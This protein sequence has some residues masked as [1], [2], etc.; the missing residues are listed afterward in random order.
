MISAAD[1]TKR[2]TDAYN[3]G[4]LAGAR[5]LLV[6]ALQI[7]PAYESAWIWLSAVVETDGERRYCLEQAQRI[8]PDRPQTVSWLAKVAGSEAAP[9]REFTQQPAVMPS[10]IAPAELPAS[11]SVAAPATDT[12][13]C[14]YCAETIQA[15]AI[16]CRYCNRDLAPQAQAQPLRSDEAT[17]LHD[18]KG[19]MCS[20]CGRATRISA[21]A[22]EYC[23]RRFVIPA[24]P[25]GQRQQFTQT[26]A[27]YVRDG[28]QVMSQTETSAQLKK[29]KQ[30]NVGGGV[31]FILM[32]LLGMVIWSGFLWLA[33]FGCVLIV[34]DYAFK[35]EESIYLTIDDVRQK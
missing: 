21:V 33:L 30:W 6:Q 19:A 13:R 22:C 3:A 24:G 26:I 7:D 27:N 2:G 28:Y 16:V 31:V 4:D 29:P 5:P 32:P 17:I 20:V 14:P 18:R 15:A 25:T 8:N 10:A 1:L 12:K 11:L 23:Q 35:R 9:P 34:L